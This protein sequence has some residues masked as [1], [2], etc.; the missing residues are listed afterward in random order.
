VP[1]TSGGRRR[2]IGPAD[3]AIVLACTLAVVLAGPR[4]DP[5]GERS[6]AASQNASSQADG[7]EPRPLA[8]PVLD[9]DGVQRRLGNASGPLIALTFDDGPDPRWTPA[10]LELLRQHRIRATFCLVGR[11]VAQ[12][13]ELVRRIAADGHAL[14]NH[15]WSH[16]EAM[17]LRSAASVSADLARTSRAITEAAG[18]PPRYY[19][20]PGGN[21]APTAVAEAGRQR[22]RLLGWSVDPYDWRRPPSTEI[23]RRVLAGA[24]PGA[25]V[26]LHDGYGA[27]ANTVA[28]LRTL[29]DALAAR[30]LRFVTP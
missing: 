13:P 28:A 14:C 23:V 5:P 24:G 10:V 7:G 15:S 17:Q 30:Q 8:A 20:A 19:R 11:H 2:G 22:L 3:L 1:G 21:W 16:D 6:A 18:R 4:A 29:L 25:I 9:A 26:L 27:R 12:H